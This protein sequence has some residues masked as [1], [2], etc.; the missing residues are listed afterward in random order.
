MF[1]YY[2]RSLYM[3]MYIFECHQQKEKQDNICNGFSPSSSKKSLLNLRPLGSFPTYLCTCSV[4]ASCT[5]SAYSRG[6]T[7]DCRQNGIFVSP[8]ACLWRE[9]E[10]KQKI[11]WEREKK[12]KKRQNYYYLGSRINQK[13]CDVSEIWICWRLKL[14]QV[15]ENFI[16]RYNITH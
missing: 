1:K 9:E 3:A 4:P 14:G 7:H 8:I 16:M 5:A 6:F 13:A 15:A 11:Q 10:I 12:R 2:L